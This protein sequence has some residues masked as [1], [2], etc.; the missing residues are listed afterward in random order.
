VPVMSQ[1]SSK[2]SD[3]Q[4]ENVHR[5]HVLFTVACIYNVRVY[6]HGDTL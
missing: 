6:V 3:M 4:T 5:E 2:V 1:T